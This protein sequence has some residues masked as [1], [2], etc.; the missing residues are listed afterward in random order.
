MPDDLDSFAPDEA[1]AIGSEVHLFVPD[2]LGRSKLAAKL[3]GKALASGTTRN[4][5]TITKLQ[6]MVDA[7]A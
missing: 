6:E 4:W 5:R 7:I 3:G 2:G 1:I